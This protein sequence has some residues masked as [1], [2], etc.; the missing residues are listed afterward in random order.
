LSSGGGQLE[1]T[2]LE[3]PKDRPSD[4]VLETPQGLGPALAFRL[5]VGDV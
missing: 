3:Q 4:P 5:P 2:R 1:L